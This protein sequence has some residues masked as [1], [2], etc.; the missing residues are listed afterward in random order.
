LNPD[1]C[2]HRTSLIG[3]ERV[4]LASEMAEMNPKN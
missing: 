4:W 1:G 2:M 3:E